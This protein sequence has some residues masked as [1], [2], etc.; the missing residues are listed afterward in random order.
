MLKRISFPIADNDEASTLLIK[1]FKWF[2]ENNILYCVQRNYEKYPENIT[3][4]VDLIVSDQ[5]L[6]FVFDNIILLARKTGWQCYYDYSWEKT[7]YI[8]L[9]KPIYPSRYTLTI[10]LF[11]GAR[12]HGLCY[13]PASLILHCRQKSGSTWKPAPCH[14]AIMTL[15]H[16]LLFYL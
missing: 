10:E 7:A 3:G 12:W 13:L 4:D 2:A 9:F 5:Q 6:R 8:G 14:Q 15:I 16:H 11:A 1:I